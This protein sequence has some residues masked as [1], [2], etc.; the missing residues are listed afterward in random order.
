MGEAVMC[1]CEGTRIRTPEGVAEV[2][3]LRVGDRVV[4]GAGVTCEISWIGRRGYITSAIFLE[5]WERLVPVRIEQ[6]ALGD[7]MPCNDLLISP[8]HAVCLENSL[9]PVRHL[10]NGDSIAYFDRPD[11]I[12]YFQLELPQ[13]ELVLAEGAAVES[14]R[15]LGDRNK[16]GNVAE[17]LA[18]IRRTMK[19]GEPC[20]PMVTA[21]ET[22]ATMRRTLAGRNPLPDPSNQPPVETMRPSRTHRMSYNVAQVV[23]GTLYRNIFNR[24]SDSAGFQYY[25]N[26]F[27]KGRKT[28]NRAV[29]EFFTSNEFVDKF[30]A[31]QTPD[32]LSRR[33]LAGFI[34]S[35]RFTDPDVKLIRTTLIRHGIGQTV[36]NLMNDARFLE[37]HGVL[38]VPRY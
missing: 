16:F 4:T 36:D 7:G 12:R 1:F 8:D 23:T 14:Y 9:V 20:L 6:G 18:R 19:P 30:A 2:Q 21:G 38:G 28:L 26:C 17:A 3:D 33:L 22:L 11:A 27:T 32:Q 13:H 37:L 25:V 29:R 34:G 5:D 35:G 24:D 15:D 10:L 31:N